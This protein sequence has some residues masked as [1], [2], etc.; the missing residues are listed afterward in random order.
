[1]IRI[2]FLQKDIEITNKD[3]LMDS[4]TKKTVSSSLQTE[5]FLKNKK[6][7]NDKQF[8]TKS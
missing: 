2:I 1:M 8:T 6:K 4:E 7:E 5:M 3:F